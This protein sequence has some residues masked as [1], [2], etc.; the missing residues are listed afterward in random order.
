MHQKLCYLHKFYICQECMAN[1]STTLCSSNN[2]VII[3]Q[4]SSIHR[5]ITLSYI[6]I[7]MNTNQKP[8]DIEKYPQIWNQG[9]GSYCC[10]LQ[11]IK[12]SGFYKT[13][14]YSIQIY[15]V[16]LVYDVF[17]SWVRS[18][19]INMQVIS[20]LK[21]QF[22][23]S[24]KEKGLIDAAMEHYTTACRS[25]NCFWSEKYNVNC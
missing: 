20:E 5:S 9:R 17:Y 10:I 11:I 8:K 14:Q 15:T 19:C 25:I 22:L 4:K 6:Y 16:Y 23:S 21:A 7:Y 24:I 3:W 18:S 13:V 2:T 1:V 12:F